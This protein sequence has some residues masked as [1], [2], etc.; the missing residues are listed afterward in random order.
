MIA[1]RSQIAAALAPEQ[2]AITGLDVTPRAAALC[3]L[4]SQSSLWEAHALTVGFAVDSADDDPSQ[5]VEML[6]DRESLSSWFDDSEF[7]RY[8]ERQHVNTTRL[9]LVRAAEFIETGLDQEA[10]KQAQ[11]GI[12]RTNYC[13]QRCKGDLKCLAQCLLS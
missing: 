13:D 12:V 11:L 3:L 9:A 7:L 10:L 6:T 8:F 2:L 5:A 1:L 4:S